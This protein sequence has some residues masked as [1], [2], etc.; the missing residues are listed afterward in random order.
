MNGITEKLEKHHCHTLVSCPATPSSLPIHNPHPYQGHKTSPKPQASHGPHAL[1]PQ[2]A[3]RGIGA[4]PD[5]TA[6]G[7]TAAGF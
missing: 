4:W 1:V 5:A 2:D 3:A 7:G 6:K